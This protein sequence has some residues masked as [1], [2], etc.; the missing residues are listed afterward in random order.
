[1]EA[2]CSTWNVA[3]CEKW[4]NLAPRR[5]VLV[6]N[7]LSRLIARK[8][9]ERSQKALLPAFVERRSGKRLEFFVLTENLAINYGKEK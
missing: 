1:M 2:K 3:K 6:N 9:I 8:G 4:Y 7:A 5:L